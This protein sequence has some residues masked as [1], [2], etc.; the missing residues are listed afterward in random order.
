MSRA[1]RGRRSF[2]F[3]F[4]VKLGGRRFE[5]VGWRE[6]RR[7]WR[8]WRIF[9]SQSLLCTSGSVYF[10]FCCPI[11]PMP[12]RARAILFLPARTRTRKRQSLA[13]SIGYILRIRH[14]IRTRYSL[15]LSLLLILFVGKST[16]ILWI[17][18]LSVGQSGLCGRLQSRRKMANIIFS[19]P[20]MIY[21]TIRRWVGS[22]WLWL[23]GRRDL[24]GII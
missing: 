3:C 19:L 12:R 18:L 24:I 13:I 22:G 14:G 1:C 21:R 17:L 2:S 23:T 16:G 6:M 10:F 11:F 5:F 20:P 4:L 8:V 7:D 15:M 9:I